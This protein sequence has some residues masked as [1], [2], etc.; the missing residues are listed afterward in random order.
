MAGRCATWGS[1]TRILHATGW[2]KNRSDAERKD[3]V[4]ALVQAPATEVQKQ[5]REVVR[6]VAGDKPAELQLRLES[7]LVQIPSR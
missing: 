7:Y 1:D 2:G 4:Q 5:A 6:E 3:D